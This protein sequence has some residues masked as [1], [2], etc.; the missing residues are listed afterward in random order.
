MLRDGRAAPIDRVVFMLH[1]VL[2]DGA[3][4]VGRAAPQFCRSLRHAMMYTSCC[5]CSLY[6]AVHSCGLRRGSATLN[7]SA[8]K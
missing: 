8:Q 7:V 4:P 1:A 6:R 3:V 5:T 2:V